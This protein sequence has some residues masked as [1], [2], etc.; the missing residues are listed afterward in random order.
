MNRVILVVTGLLNRDGN[1][2]V[3]AHSSATLILSGNAAILVD[4]SS[5]ERRAELLNNLEEIGIL[6]SQVD[7]VVLTHMHHDH[8]GNLELFPEARKLARVEEGDFDGIE[9]ITNDMELIPG[10]TLMHTPGHTEGSMSV[11]VDSGDATYVI[12]GDAIPT[13]D[14]HDRWIPPGINIDPE[15]ALSSMKCICQIG[16]I[17]I[18]GHGEPFTSCDER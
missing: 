11:V 17:V 6:P 8:I 7:V 16:N 14:N 9:Q 18:P 12:T 1:Q 4:T 3:E 15:L 13:K 10:V 2:I 5:I